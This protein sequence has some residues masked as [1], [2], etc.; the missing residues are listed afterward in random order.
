MYQGSRSGQPPLAPRVGTVEGAA[1]HLFRPMYAQ[2][3]MGHPSRTIDRCY[4]VQGS[5]LCCWLRERANPRCSRVARFSGFG[6]RPSLFILKIASPAE[7][8]CEFSSVHRR[9]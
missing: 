7:K 3:N 8:F 5:G 1:P 4:P 2:A 6:S 9:R